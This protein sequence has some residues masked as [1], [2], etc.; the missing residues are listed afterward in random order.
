LDSKRSSKRIRCIWV[1]TIK[2]GKCH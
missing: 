1:Y 2:M